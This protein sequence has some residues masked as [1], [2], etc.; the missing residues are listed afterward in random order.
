MVYVIDL[1]IEQTVATCCMQSDEHRARARAEHSLL[2]GLRRRL[3][4]SEGRDK[5]TKEISPELFT[6]K[7][8]LKTRRTQPEEEGEEEHSRQME[9][10]GEGKQEREKKEL[11]TCLGLGEGRCVCRESKP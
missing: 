5:R 9:S 11:V 1:K 7:R 10:F 6:S 4:D 8:N 3:C 2:V